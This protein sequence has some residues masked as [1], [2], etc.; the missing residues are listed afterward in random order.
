MHNAHPTIG[1]LMDYAAK[2]AHPSI[3]LAS[4]CCCLFGIDMFRGLFCIDGLAHC[5][6]GRARLEPGLCGLTGME[7]SLGPAI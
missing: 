7:C 5:V 3:L 2:G 4:F 6:S 1:T